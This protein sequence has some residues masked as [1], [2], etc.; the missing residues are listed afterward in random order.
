[1]LIEKGLIFLHNFNK[2]M[3]VINYITIMFL[4]PRKKCF[5]YHTCLLQHM[6]TSFKKTGS[7]LL[8]ELRG[9][10]TA[11]DL[12]T[13]LAGLGDRGSSPAMGPQRSNSGG[14]GGT[15]LTI[16]WSLS[17]NQWMFPNAFVGIE[18]NPQKRPSGV[19]E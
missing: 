18:N 2:N 3:T 12:W 15:N 7:M 11:R 4:V 14:P 13:L 1:M 17:T 19:A 5:I 16:L 8:P 9:S 10:D 6:E